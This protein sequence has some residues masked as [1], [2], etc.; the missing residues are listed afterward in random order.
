MSFSY[1]RQP[2]ILLNDT[3]KITA[4][5]FLENEANDAAAGCF[6]HRRR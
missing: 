2:V 6:H 4:L 1:Q 3:N 5:L